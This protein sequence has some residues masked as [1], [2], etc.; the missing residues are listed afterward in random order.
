LGLGKTTWNGVGTE[1]TK[2]VVRVADWGWGRSL[3]GELDDE[4]SALDR[5]DVDVARL[6]VGIVGPGTKES[7]ASST[8]QLV[9]LW[10]DIKES[11]FLDVFAGR[12]LWDRANIPDSETCTVVGLIRKSIDDI[13]VVVNIACLSLEVTGILWVLEVTNVKDVGCWKLVDGGWA[14]DCFNLIVLIVHNEVFLVLQI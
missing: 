10:V 3:C 5:V 2:T 4:R 9:V 12:I 8:W 11:N 7:D 6:E 13:L 14:S 1:S